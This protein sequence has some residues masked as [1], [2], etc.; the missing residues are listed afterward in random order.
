[1]SDKLATIAGLIMTP[2]NVD[3]IRRR[4]KWQT[5]RLVKPGGRTYRPGQV[6]Y[7]KEQHGHGSSAPFLRDRVVWYQSDYWAAK[8]DGRWIDRDEFERDAKRCG[9]VWRSPMFMP[10]ALAQVLIQIDAVRTEPVQSI[11]LAD[12]AA[13]GYATVNGVADFHRGFSSIN[14]PAAWN[15]NRDVTVYEFH[16]ID[17]D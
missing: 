15:E 5:R 16:L 11:T 6:L 13:E 4:L 9:V 14:G 10:R 7:L 12:A 17:Q 3:L 8:F 1:M 2:R